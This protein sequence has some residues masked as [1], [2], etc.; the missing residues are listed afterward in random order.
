MDENNKTGFKYYCK[1]CDYKTNNRSGY[2]QHTKTKKHIKKS[3]K[4]NPE[5]IQR[6][7][8]SN[9][10]QNNLQCPNCEYVFKYKQG[11]WKHTKLNR[12]KHSNGSVI[13]S[14]NTNSN[15][16]TNNITN[17][18]VFNVNSPEE[19]Q[20]IKSILTDEKILEI[21][22]SDSWGVP[23]QSYDMM[24]KIQSLSI[25]SKKQNPEL[26]NFKKT[27]A[28]DDLIDVLENNVFKK[29]HFKEYNREDLCKYADII[30]N[31]CSDIEP[32]KSHYE[33]IDIIRDI[34]R[35]YDH[36][37]SI[38]NRADI[39]G[40]AM[41]YCVIEAIN[42]CE[43]DSKLAHYNITTGNGNEEEEDIKE[44]ETPNDS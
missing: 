35:D 9:P 36:Y 29:T 19:V 21:C 26:C 3:S 31:R 1:I 25:E 22:Q 32:C 42:E 14:H 8:K 11:L 39:S 23:R 33:K 10:E 12:C 24:K 30:W 7:S 44:P 16:I 40:S 4:S 28:R 18:I 43:R 13:N 17:N 41:I 37:K 34:L 5:V 20:M 27:N 15:N 38:K 2:Y 6:S